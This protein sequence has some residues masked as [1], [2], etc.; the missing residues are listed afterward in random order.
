MGKKGNILALAVIVVFCF[1]GLVPPSSANNVFSQSSK[2]VTADDDTTV[3]VTVTDSLGHIRSSD[4]VARPPAT[5]VARVAFLSWTRRTC[6]ITRTRSAPLSLALSLRP[7]ID[8]KERFS[9]AYGVSLPRDRHYLPRTL[10]Q[11]SPLADQIAE[12]LARATIR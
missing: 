2:L 4:P 5:A 11:D 12:S 1:L 8:L 10:G 3:S 9:K 7:S 6:L